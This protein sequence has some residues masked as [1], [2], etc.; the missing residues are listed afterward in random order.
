MLLQSFRS[1][2]AREET[3][4]IKPATQSLGRMS[5][6]CGLKQSVNREIA[7]RQ[8]E[9]NSV[10]IRFSFYGSDFPLINLYRMSP[11]RVELATFGFGG[12]RS[13]QLSYGDGGV[14]QG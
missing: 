10:P 11:A 8:I 4:T 14:V 5:G 1:A 13:I 6:N 12:R 9:L 3:G 2:S 7:E